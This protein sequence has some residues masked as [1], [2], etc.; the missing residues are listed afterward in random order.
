MIDFYSVFINRK[1]L[2]AKNTKKNK[3]E[4]EENKSG[5][6]KKLNNEIR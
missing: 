4:K 2:I 1:F 6:H 5:K 3:I